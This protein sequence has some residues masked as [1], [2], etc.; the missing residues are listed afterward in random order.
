MLLHCW[1]ECKLLKTLWETVW[2][3]LKKL[4]IELPYDPVMSFLDI[5]P[6]KI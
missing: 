2:R 3:F 5:Y 1:L 6:G 4:I